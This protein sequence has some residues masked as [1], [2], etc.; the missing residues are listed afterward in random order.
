MTYPKTY[1][2]QRIVQAKLYIDENFRENINVDNIAEEA[3][4]SKF[5]F[6]RLFKS[7]YGFSP[8]QYLINK[9][10]EFSKKRI[11]ENYSVTETCFESGFSSIGTFST[12]F[13]TKTGMSPTHYRDHFSREQIEMESKP[14]KYIPGCFL[15]KSNFQEIN[16]TE[17]VEI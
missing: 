15:Q 3:N 5:H 13:K 14:E 8:R 17:C 1:L 11:K 6:I 9:R 7:A 10:I 2:Y 16:V 4:F 12:L